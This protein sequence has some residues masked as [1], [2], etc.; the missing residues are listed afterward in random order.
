MSDKPVRIATRGS[1]LALA[2]AKEV[3]ARLRAAH[4]L[5]EA[6][7]EIL[8]LRTT[9]DR[10]QDR[11]LAE[12]GGKG[13]FTKEIEEALIDGR[14]NIAVHS[15]K[16]VPTWLPDGLILSSIL[17]REDVRDAFVS[18]IAGSLADLPEGAVVGTASL[19]RQALVL[20]ARPDLTVVTLRGNVQ[21]RLSKLDSGDVQ[22]TL[23]ALAGLKRL[24]AES[25][26][27]ALFDVDTFPPALGQGAIAIETRADDEA[28]NRLVAAINH[29]D[30]AIALACERAFLAVLDGSC[31]T[32]IAGHAS[33][34]DGTLRFHGLVISPDGRSVFEASRI[35]EPADAA[36]IGRSAGE[37]VI[38]RAGEEFLATLRT[39]H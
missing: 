8:V 17:E 29:E 7:T 6:D 20:R 5:A 23:L 10:I 32:P 12:A 27:A 11:T 36:A 9:G 19:R 28:T 35:G 33:I 1:L 14:A 24:G 21:T 30:T 15:A 34:D 3:A 39:A 22:A 2:Q 16:D 25:E 13:L 38:G 4:G 18:R 26:A 31:R 37:D